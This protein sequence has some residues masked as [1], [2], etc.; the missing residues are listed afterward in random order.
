MHAAPTFLVKGQADR[1]P[2]RILRAYV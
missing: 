2:D 1:I